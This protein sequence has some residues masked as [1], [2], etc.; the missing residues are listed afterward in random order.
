MGVINNKDKLYFFYHFYDLHGSPVSCEV[1]MAN[2]KNK[3]TSKEK[4]K[5]K[6]QQQQ[7]QQQQKCRTASKHFINIFQAISTR[8]FLIIF[9]MSLQIFFC[10][11]LVFG[12]PFFKI[13]RLSVPARIVLPFPRLHSK[14]SFGKFNFLV[15]QTLSSICP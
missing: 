15:E 5:T 2:K 14:C 12:S 7:Q 6:Q 3:Q 10:E 13:S 4:N 8:F 1:L 11:H 9:S